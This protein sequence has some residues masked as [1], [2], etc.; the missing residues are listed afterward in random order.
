MKTL[1]RET[2]Y[3]TAVVVEEALAR[4]VRESLGEDLEKTSEPVSDFQLIGQSMKP[5]PM[6]SICS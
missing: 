6:N 5:T 1:Y 3:V 2:K 4:I